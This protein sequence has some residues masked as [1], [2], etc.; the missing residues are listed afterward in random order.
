LHFDHFDS[1]KRRR[2]RRQEVL[3]CDNVWAVW[4]CAGR[5]LAGSLSEV[6]HQTRLAPRPL[7]LF[8]ATLLMAVA[9]LLF[10]LD[11]GVAGLYIGVFLAAFSFG[12]VSPD[13]LPASA[14]VLLTGI[15]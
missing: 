11:L 5:I 13:N 8:F 2:R 10:W 3:L 12:A 15:G 7:N 4:K 14:H 1:E 6:I 9:Q